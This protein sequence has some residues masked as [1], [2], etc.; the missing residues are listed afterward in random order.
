MMD[1]AVILAVVAILA[2]FAWNRF[3]RERNPQARVM[4]IQCA[5]NLKGIGNAFNLWADSHSGYYPM[6]LSEAIGGSEEFTTG[7]NASRHFQV[8]SNA[9]SSPRALICPADERIKR[10]VSARS[11][12]AVGNA[13]LSYFVGIDAKKGS[14][15]SFLSGDRNITN[16][17]GAKD[18][19]LALST[20]SPAGWTSE[21][22]DGKGA[23]LFADGSVRQLTASDLQLAIAQTGL[24]TNH[25][26]MPVI[27]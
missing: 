3:I 6:S 13:N 9:I 25:L 24:A 12:S 22:H 18:G 27:P 17:I 21:I 19:I 23:I 8:L 20:N 11:L 5:N 4:R 26:Q 7:T 14:S 10:S 16:A 2:A 1:V 15:T